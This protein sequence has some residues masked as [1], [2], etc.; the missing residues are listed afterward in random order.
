[1]LLHGFANKLLQA[2]NGCFCR[3]CILYIPLGYIGNA[4]AEAKPEHNNLNYAEKYNNMLTKKCK[5]FH[6]HDTKNECWTNHKTEIVQQKRITTNNCNNRVIGCYDILLQ[7]LK[8]KR[9]R[10]LF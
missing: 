8:F 1:V 3:F 5:G 2:T 4:K 7:C 9:K 6:E 10:L